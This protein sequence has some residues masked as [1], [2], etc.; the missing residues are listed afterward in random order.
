M[1]NDDHKTYFLYDENNLLPN[2]IVLR[3]KKLSSPYGIIESTN[4]YFG[5]SKDKLENELSIVQIEKYYSETL[6]EDYYIFMFESEKQIEIDE[7]CNLS[8]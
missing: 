6:N 7:L 8:F 5:V 4:V 1:F 2:G 3:G